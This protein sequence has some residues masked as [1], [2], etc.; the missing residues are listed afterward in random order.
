MFKFTSNAKVAKVFELLLLSVYDESYF[1]LYT[2]ILPDL[3]VL[4]TLSNNLLSFQLSPL[5]TFL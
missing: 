2:E 3:K 5:K 1:L 4:L